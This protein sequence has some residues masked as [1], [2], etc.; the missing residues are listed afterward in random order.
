[1][2][3]LYTRTDLTVPG[4]GTLTHLAQLEEINQTQARMVRLIQVEAGTPTG[5]WENG[6]SRGVVTVPQTEV[7]HPD[8]YGEFEGLDA[9][10][11]TAEQFE[12]AWSRV[13]SHLG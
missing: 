3:T 10:A 13:Q 4:A 1:M 2:R 11:L 6:T 9:Q 7:P 8:T 5:T 12:A